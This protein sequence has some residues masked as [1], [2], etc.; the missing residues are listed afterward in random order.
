MKLIKQIITWWVVL[1]SLLALYASPFLLTG[2]VVMMFLDPTTPLWALITAVIALITAVTL[3]LIAAI[4]LTTNVR[5]FY[6]EIYE[7][8]SVE[9]YEYE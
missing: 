6:E 2:G 1:T 4:I 5:L 8:I 3:A 9:Y 7:F